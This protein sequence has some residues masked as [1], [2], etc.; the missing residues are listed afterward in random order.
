MLR[1]T[2][3][4]TA[5]MLSISN[6]AGI[7]TYAD[8]HPTGVGIHSSPKLS[9][10]EEQKENERIGLIV[11]TF[12]DFTQVDQVKGF[13]ES[14]I[15]RKMS[16]IGPNTEEIITDHGVYVKIPEFMWYP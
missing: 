1:K 4:L 5:V 12:G 6:F 13:N 10:A 2:I 8:H 7:S 3:L 11:A 9:A 16:D 15:A 14:E